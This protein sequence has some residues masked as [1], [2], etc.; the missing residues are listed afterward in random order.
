M[1]KPFMKTIFMA[2]MVIIV[3]FSLT[4]CGKTKDS[5][6]DNAP[7]Q[8]NATSDDQ[9]FEIVER[10]EGKIPTVILYDKDG[11]KV[12]LSEP[13]PELLQDVDFEKAGK[14]TLENNTDIVIGVAYAELYVNR[15]QNTE[16]LIE[17]IVDPGKED[18]L[19]LDL[20]PYKN[21][22]GENISLLKD[23]DLY[24]INLV[25][26][27]TDINAGFVPLN[28]LNLYIPVGSEEEQQAFLAKF[29][30]E[31]KLVFENDDLAFYFSERY[32]DDPPRESNNTQRVYEFL[33]KNKTDKYLTFGDEEKTSVN[34]TPV[35][36]FAPTGN[37]DAYN[38]RFAYTALPKQDD[39][40]SQIL[41][42][43]EIK[44]FMSYNISESLNGDL[45]KEENFEFMF[46]P[47]DFGLE[48][49][50]TAEEVKY[51]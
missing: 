35:Q 19:I 6:G 22:R 36:L 4:A 47:A 34:G 7:D 5:S 20:T 33:V 16:N 48:T 51:R 15:I 25:F 14:L 30:P 3:I 18:S 43:D 37:I 17:L 39:D 27:I 8:N 46:K 13:E 9:G 2:V 21:T 42:F 12:S 11:V 31:E 24:S 10:P 45:I 26:S 49:T 1:K 29:T 41:Q 23:S 38:Y 40:G 32:K 50:A 28:E 44:H